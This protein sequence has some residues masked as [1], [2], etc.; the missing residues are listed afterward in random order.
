MKFVALLFIIL[1]I[2]AMLY[3]QSVVTNSPGEHMQYF[4][5]KEEEMAKKY[6]SYMSE[7]AHGGR[8]RKLEKRREEVVNSLREAIRE[9]GRV[10]PY[11]GDASLRDS[12]R[13][14]W[15]VMLS[16][17]VEDYHKIVDM[18]EIAERSYDAMEVYL[19][20]QEKAG[21]KAGQAI[22]KLKTS[23]NAFAA[24]NSIQLV[25][26]PET[27]LSK[28]I[29]KA[30]EVNRYMNEIFLISFK[31]SVQ[32]TQMLE[33]LNKQDVNA[34]EQFRNSMLKFTD[35][36][37]ARLDTLKPFKGD[38]SYLNVTRRLLE[39]Q[40]SEAEKMKVIVDFLL[41]SEELDKI[42]AA[43]ENKPAAKRTQDDVDAFNQAISNFN[44]SVNEYN[45]TNNELNNS[46]SRVRNNFETT[47]KR[48]MDQHVPH[49]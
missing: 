23:Y 7:V 28:K 10:R 33:A 5:N 32:E 49:A 30:G 46:R 43:Y 44:K 41:K 29:N 14:F 39:F 9:S 16:I 35:E 2:P 13:E 20:T 19:L 34:V 22:E 25:E 1:L 18:E 17:F 37:L 45:K 27:K 11:N 36:G 12:Y 6:M 8:A 31:S 15:T 21:E 38:G 4:T 48:F 3:P 26:S 24:A 40:K 42:K 47:R